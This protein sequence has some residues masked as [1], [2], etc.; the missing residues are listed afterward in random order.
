[1]QAQ[2]TLTLVGLCRLDYYLLK[3]YYRRGK[4]E[5][6]RADNN[7]NHKQP[8]PHFVLRETVGKKAH[9]QAG[10]TLLLRLL[11]AR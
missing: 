7:S 10:S 11:V 6:K 2:D 4:A 5:T 8:S 3:H 1:M 9:D